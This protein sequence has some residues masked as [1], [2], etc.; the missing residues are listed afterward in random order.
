MFS[1]N[2]LLAWNIRYTLRSFGLFVVKAPM[3]YK[4]YGGINW[5][6]CDSVGSLIL[7]VCE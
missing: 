5:V 3:L 4:V 7:V 2:A 1:G 6:A